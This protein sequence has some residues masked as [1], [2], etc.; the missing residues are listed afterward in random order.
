MKTILAI[1]ILAGGAALG[2]GQAAEHITLKGQHLGES[3]QQFDFS[4][5]PKDH[6]QKEC[7]KAHSWAGGIACWAAW[8]LH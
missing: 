8:L 1:A 6:Q 7:K 2:H 3:W 4:A 5:V